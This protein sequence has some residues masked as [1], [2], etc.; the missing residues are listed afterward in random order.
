MVDPASVV[1]SVKPTRIF[2]LDDHELVGR[3][4]IDLL[5][6]ADDLVDRR[7]QQRPTCRDLPN[8]LH[9]VVATD[10]LEQISRSC[11]IGSEIP[12]RLTR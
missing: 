3:G 9:Q 11:L 2:I 12:S 4:L 1:T 5:T 7:I 10:L 6:A 8:A